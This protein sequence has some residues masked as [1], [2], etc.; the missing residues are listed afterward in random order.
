MGTPRPLPT[1]NKRFRSTIIDNR[2][3]VCTECRKG[4]FKSQEYKWTSTGYIHNG[5]ERQD[6][7]IKEST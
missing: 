1:F 5:C 3:S 2:V 6:D 4:I 7:T